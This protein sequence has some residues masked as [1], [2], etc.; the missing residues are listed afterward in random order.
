MCDA[1]RQKIACVKAEFGN[2]PPESLARVL[3]DFES[4]ADIYPLAELERAIDAAARN[5]KA[6]LAGIPGPTFP[7]HALVLQEPPANLV[8]EAA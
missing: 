7:R 8:E 1:L 2:R 4:L 3:A 6:I 5:A